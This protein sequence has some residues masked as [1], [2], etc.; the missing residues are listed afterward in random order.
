M[1]NALTATVDQFYCDPSRLGH[2]DR[3]VTNQV[4]CIE[5]PG[6]WDFPISVNKL[7]E[8]CQTLFWD[9]DLNKSE[10][11]LRAAQGLLALLWCPLRCGWISGS[12]DTLSEFRIMAHKITRLAIKRHFAQR[13]QAA[14]PEPTQL[15]EQA[16]FT[17]LVNRK[18]DI[19]LF[20]TREGPDAYVR[21]S[22]F[23]L[24]PYGLTQK[25]LQKYGS[26]AVR[27]FFKFAEHQ[28]P[29]LLVPISIYHELRQLLVAAGASSWITALQA[30]CLRQMRW[31]ALLPLLGQGADRDLAEVKHAAALAAP[32][33]FELADERGRLA[34]LSAEGLSAILL[35][36]SVP[37]PEL[38]I[39]RVLREYGRERPSDF[40]KLELHKVLRLYGFSSDEF[41]RVFIAGGAGHHLGP[42]LC[43]AVLSKEFD[44]P[45]PLRSSKEQVAG[46]ADAF[47]ASFPHALEQL[48]TEDGA[49]KL[50]RDLLELS[51]GVEAALSESEQSTL[52]ILR[53]AL[54]WRKKDAPL[55]KQLYALFERSID[56]QIE[57]AEKRHFD[58]YGLDLEVFVSPDLGDWHEHGRVH[59]QPLVATSQVRMHPEIW[60]RGLE[61][62]EI[63]LEKAS[64]EALSELCRYA[65]GIP[66]ELPTVEFCNLL[67]DLGGVKRAQAFIDALPEDLGAAQLGC[68]IV[69]LHTQLR[70]PRAYL[71]LVMRLWNSLNLR[72]VY[73]TRLLQILED[74]GIPGKPERQWQLLCLAGRD[75][76]FLR[77]AFDLIRW[78]EDALAF[79]TNFGSTKSPYAHLLTTTT[80][81]AWLDYFA[82]GK[83]RPCPAGVRPQPSIINIDMT[84]PDKMWLA[85]IK[86]PERWSLELSDL[87]SFK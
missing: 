77:A 47:H 72:R 8:F 63:A 86:H 54:S 83:Q 43:A 27:F 69:G 22:L 53:N 81:L 44:D 45:R 37:G 12:I 10:F 73:D 38:E 39:W 2:S 25:Q 71:R 61:K 18:A 64:N 17:P 1:N 28:D 15:P 79:Q 85:Q 3:L 36:D 29:K 80:R 19:T 26:E 57:H 40:A 13:L 31:R 16:K 11:S 67:C 30:P 75:D 33:F 46:S 21:G 24:R 70:L 68:Y 60:P 41:S 58:Q 87:I 84:A 20:Q 9:F 82:S 62:N 14:Q 66:L 35:C 4:Q 23:T 74:G 76:E 50:A 34:Q 55:A 51:A 65:H 48:P 7:S 52:L 59:G 5:S 42:E 49:A 56:L 32:H 78:E 6:R